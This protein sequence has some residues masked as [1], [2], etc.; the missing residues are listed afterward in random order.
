MTPRLPRQMTA[1]AALLL[2][3]SFSSALAERPDEPSAIVGAVPH[4]VAGAREIAR[5]DGEARLERVILVLPQRDPQGLARLLADQHDPA[6]PEFRRWLSPAEFET[7]FGASDEDVVALRNWL[8]GHGLE[9]E[10]APAGRAALVF[11]GRASD[12][13]SAFD[14]ELHEVLAGNQVRIANT[15]PPRLPLGLARRVVGVLSLHTFPRRRPLAR[16]VPYNTSGSTHFL[17]PADFTAIY[18]VDA[19]AASGINGSG[20]TIGI[21]G[22]TNVNVADTT[23]FRSNFGLPANDPVVVL[24]GPDPGIQKGDETES[25]LD[26][27]WAGA[28][29]P[30]ART[31][32]ITSKATINAVDLSALYAVSNNLADVLSLSYGDCELDFADSDT[33]LYT[34]VWAQA[35]AQGISVFVSSGDTG[36]TGTGCSST[37]LPSVSGLCSSPYATCVGGTQFDDTVSPSTYWNSTNDPATQ[38]SAKGYIPETTWNDLGG[39]TGGGKSIL[40]SRPPWQNVSSLPADGARYVP[41]VSVAGAT[42]TPYLMVQ[43]HTTGSSG[44]VSVG[45]TSASAP[46]F[47]G[48]AALLAQKAGGRLG[49][50]NPLLYAVGRSQYGLANASG[51]VSVVA[52]TSAFH[53]ITTGNNSFA[54]VTGFAAGPGYDATTGLGSVDAFALASALPGPAPATTDFTLGATPATPILAAGGSVAVS[55]TLDQIGAANADAVATVTLAGLPAGVTAEFRPGNPANTGVG[56]VARAQPATLTLTSTGA[57]APGTYRLDLTATSGSVVRRIA[58]FLTVGSGAAPPPSGTIVQAPVVLDVFGAASS[59]FTSDFVAVNRSGSDATLVLVYVPTAGPPGAAGPAVARTLPAGR[60]LYIPDVIAFLAANGW[61]LPSDGSGKLGTFFA[62]FVG[63]TDPAAVFAGSRTSTPNLSASV[64]GAFGLF[65]TAVHSGGASAS[66]DTW[67]YGLRENAS[68]RSNLAVVHA[69][70]AASGATS[71]SVSLEIQLYDGDSGAAVGAPLTRTLQPG[72]FFQYNQVLKN[73]PAALTNGYARLTRTSGADRFIAYGVVNDGGS[74]GG[75]TSDGSFLVANATEGLVPILLDLPGQAHFTSDLT[76]TNPTSSA[77]TVSLTYT[78]STSAPFSGA[79]SGTRTTTLAAGQ[80]LVVPNAIAFLRGL[81]LPI[82]STGGQAGTLLVTGAAAQ[83]RTS[84]PNPDA[85]VGGSYGLSYPAVSTL[86]RARGEA[87][88]YG[89]RQ[90]ED[91]RS[92]LAIAD[93]RV[94][95]GV[96]VTYLVDVF[97]ADTGAAAPVQTLSLSLAGGQWSQVNGILSGAGITHG[98]VRVRPSSGTSDFVVY[99]VV[100]DGPT[101]GS[102]TSDGSYVPMVVT[103]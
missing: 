48:I 9:V 47:A 92:N 7:R 36:V 55:L 33:A 38:K 93:A 42:H 18:N 64:G 11:S 15:R 67:I 57:P 91:V 88:V 10:D 34:N 52:G 24:N 51:A 56:V 66:G 13:E 83:A 59:H 95:N 43:G 22:Q 46:A 16:P 30:S 62:A 74:A 32:L 80:Q 87:W 27:Q 37:T 70:G 76:L 71:G 101:A 23:F 41:D 89:L 103:N 14:T 84:N 81:G 45:G 82:P 19:L 26:L 20:R 49:N 35:A 17:A 3:A 6:S 102:R 2:A 79:G 85:T 97:D 44:L 72:E 40:F 28:I 60:Q 63:V 39:S 25:D 21:L 65:A 68:F 98:Y 73:A 31:L 100:N 12:V 77:V 53:D 61:S 1:F 69:P 86:G 78:A 90:D 54:G 8:T 58:L 50:L 99:G 4:E 75:G 94:G 29:A 5:L 96:A